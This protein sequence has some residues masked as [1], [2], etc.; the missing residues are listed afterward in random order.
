VQL[1]NRPRVPAPAVEHIPNG[2]ANR[3]RARH[4]PSIGRSAL[5]LRNSLVQ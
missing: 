5:N 3:A 4:V 2:V 1:V